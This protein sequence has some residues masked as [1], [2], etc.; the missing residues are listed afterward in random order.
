[1]QRGPIWF[2]THEAVGYQCLHSSFDRSRNT[3]A[4]SCCPTSWEL[5]HEV[6]W[7]EAKSEENYGRVI[8]RCMN[9]FPLVT[10]GLPASLALLVW[11]TPSL[12]STVCVTLLVLHG[13]PGS[14]A[15]SAL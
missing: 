9:L 6:Y 12:P 13:P 14:L 15:A 3:V 7:Q 10:I 11:V 8:L 2:K 5:R 1:M 4:L